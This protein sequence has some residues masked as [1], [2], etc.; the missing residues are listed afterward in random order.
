MLPCRRMKS[1][2]LAEVMVAVSSR[3]EIGWNFTRATVQPRVTSFTSKGELAFRG[4]LSISCRAGHLNAVE[5]VALRRVAPRRAAQQPFWAA[6]SV[7][8]TRTGLSQ[9]DK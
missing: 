4:R 6:H 5:L 2:V 1:N 8:S 7:R 9:R 3:I